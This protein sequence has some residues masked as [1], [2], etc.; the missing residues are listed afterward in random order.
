MLKKTLLCLLVM[1]ALLVGAC[2]G[3]EVRQNER[4]ITVYLFTVEMLRDYAPYI[5]AQL[6]DVE[7][8]F[9][10]G[11]NDLDF[12]KFLKE[13][14]S[15]PDIFTNRRFALHDAAQLRE[16]LLDLSRTD[17]AASIYAGFLDNY[18]NKDG[19]INWLP[20]CGEPDGFVANKALFAKYNI[21][22]PHDYASF[23]FAC[24]EFAKHGIRGFV[25]DFYYDYTP[26][27]ILQ[28]LSISQLQSLEGQKWRLAYENPKGN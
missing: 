27:E 7:L 8:Q 12:Y 16:Q 10:V 11:N 13:Q 6:P 5:Q 2:G 9:V 22:L 20:L 26:M 3:K 19:T 14:G 15:L 24:K 18:K 4:P 1:V 23:R 17:A 28:G 21:P 25:S